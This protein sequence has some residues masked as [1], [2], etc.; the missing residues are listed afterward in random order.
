MI[1]IHAHTYICIVCY[2]RSFPLLCSIRFEKE[3]MY[4]L[5]NYSACNRSH[6]Y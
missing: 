5:K 6:D 3:R 2:S 1:H 4:M